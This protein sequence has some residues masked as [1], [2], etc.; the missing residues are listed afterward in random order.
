MNT[1]SLA[2]GLIPRLFPSFSTLYGTLKS[3]EGP[4][5][6]ADFLRR[7]N[8][9]TCTYQL[10]QFE[11]QKNVSMDQFQQS[12]LQP[13][14]NTQCKVS[15]RAPRCFEQTWNTRKLHRSYLTQLRW[16]S[17]WG[18]HWV[19]LVEV[20]ARRFEWKWLQVL[21]LRDWVEVQLGLQN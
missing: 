2:S 4:Q 9:S 8:Q 12:L 10:F 3:W 14:I 21:L 7:W 17:L 16:S 1:F 18:F 20:V 6:E 19:N 15:G 13:D 5:H 11:Q